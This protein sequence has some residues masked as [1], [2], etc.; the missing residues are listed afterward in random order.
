MAIQQDKQRYLEHHLEEDDLEQDEFILDSPEVVEPEEK[1]P[2][3]AKQQGNV[4]LILSGLQN[5]NLSDDESDNESL[6]DPTEHH[7]APKS[8]ALKEIVIEEIHVEQPTKEDGIKQDS[9]KVIEQEESPKQVEKPTKGVEE[10]PVQEEKPKQAFEEVEHE[11]KE[12]EPLE[13]EI[14]AK[15]QAPAT[16]EP[17][18]EQRTKKASASEIHVAQIAVT[19]DHKQETQ[20][21]TQ[22]EGLSELSN[23]L[24]N[25]RPMLE[26]PQPQHLASLLPAVEESVKTMRS[27][28][29]FQAAKIQVETSEVE[30][31]D[32]KQKANKEEDSGFQYAMEDTIDMDMFKENVIAIQAIDP[33]EIPVNIL[34]PHEQEVTGNKRHL[35][36][37]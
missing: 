36:R 16:Y 27:N 35:I 19:E 12:E 25:L 17:I 14:E 29:K 15:Q 23:I 5:H 26:K 37:G 24:E 32:T 8:E 28:N 21:A 11:T 22:E 7:I 20:A 4:S 10:H 9:Q 34:K 33:K 2:E 18:P 1:K 13:Q 31:T 6:K 30:V 3:E